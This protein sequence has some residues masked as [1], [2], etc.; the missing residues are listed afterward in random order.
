MKKII[1]IGITLALIAAMIIPTGVFAADVVISGG[2]AIPTIS[3]ISPASGVQGNTYT[4]VTI[5]GTY[6]TSAS[7]VTFG[8]T[9]VT[10]DTIVVAGNG[11]SLTCTVSIGSS[12]TA[13]VR[14]VSVTTPGGTATKTSA[15]T[16]TASS[17][18]VT[19]PVVAALGDM[20]RGET[21][22]ATASPAGSVDTNAQNWEVAAKDEKTPNVGYMV[23]TGPTPLDA[24]FQIS[25]TSTTEDLANAD[26]GITYDETS[27]PTKSLPFYVSQVIASD[28]EAGSYS[29][30]ITFTGTCQ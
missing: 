7:A 4:L 10:A 18:T 5:S 29:I 24:K 1:T 23:K 19:A 2:V 26:T 8:G 30:T 12:A 11:L 16:V 25:R 15:F 6:L 22:T 17:I 20:V 9:L 3:T 13:D 14:D 21:V 27:N 28:E